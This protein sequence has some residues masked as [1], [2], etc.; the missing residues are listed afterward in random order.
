MA[1]TKIASQ[2]SKEAYSDQT[3]YKAMEVAMAATENINQPFWECVQNYNDRIEADE[4]CVVMVIA[5]DPLVKNL[6]RRKFY[7][8]PWLPSPRPNQTVLLFNKKLQKFTKRLWVLPN[9]ITM[10]EL[11]EPSLIVDPAYKT[12]Q[13]WSKAFFKG[14]FWEY[15]R[16]EH[17]I[18]MLSQEEYFKLHA[19]DLEN[20]R[21]ELIKSNFNEANLNGTEAFDFSKIQVKDMEHANAPIS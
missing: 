11:T 10:A 21:K 14:C 20:T 4:F 1:K 12:M 8:W 16:K 5:S 9:A 2:L 17:K 13:K 18:D 6:M 19:E 7:C 15:V 3:K